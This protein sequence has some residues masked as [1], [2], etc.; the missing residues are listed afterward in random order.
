VTKE[1]L[2]DLLLPKYEGLRPQLLQYFG[3]RQVLSIDVVKTTINEVNLFGEGPAQFSQILNLS[4]KDASS[5][6]I[7]VLNESRQPF[8]TMGDFR[9]SRD[10]LKRWRVQLNH[11]NRQDFYDQVGSAGWSLS[12]QFAG[13]QVKFMAPGPEHG[14]WVAQIKAQSRN[15]GWLARYPKVVQNSCTRSIWLDQKPQ[16]WVI[17]EWAD[18]VQAGKDL[19][20]EETAQYS[21]WQDSR[22]LY[23]TAL[24]AQYL[25]RCGLNTTEELPIYAHPDWS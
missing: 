19:T 20:V 16:D 10:S 9:P 12:D 24:P 17:P 13:T 1:L 11:H 4:E 8:L 5:M 15:L 6:T 25:V 7:E 2:D 23:G 18:K 3:S 14:L 22:S 21:E